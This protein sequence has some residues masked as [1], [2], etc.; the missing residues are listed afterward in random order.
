MKKHLWEQAWEDQKFKLVTSKPSVIVERYKDNFLPG[1]FVLDVGC[2]NGRNS[3]YLAGLGC[4]VDC[5]DV[6]D[7]NW[8]SSLPP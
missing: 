5:F 2:G 3:I 4:H 7:T 8:T 1:D 6:A